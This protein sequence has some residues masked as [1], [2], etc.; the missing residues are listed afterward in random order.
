M[1]GKVKSIVIEKICPIIED[2]G[3]DVE[4]DYTKESDGMNLTF[5]I[6]CDKGVDIDDCE[7]VSKIID[8][9]LDELNPTD[10]IPYTLNVSSPGIDKPLKSERDFNRNLGK[11]IE[12]TLFAK[13]NGQKVFKG[14]LISF[15]QNI[16]TIKNEETISFAREKIAHIVPVIEF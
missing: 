8:P 6:D 11:K 5:Y 15:D 1:A 4:V 13:M 16:V 14:Q 7:K 10:D 12:I 3:Y 9:L 2:M